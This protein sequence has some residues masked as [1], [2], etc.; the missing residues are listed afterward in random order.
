MLAANHMHTT[1]MLYVTWLYTM[2]RMYWSVHAL[3]FNC[4]LMINYV[5]FVKSRLMFN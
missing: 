1:L 3:I 5:L 4:A 2:S